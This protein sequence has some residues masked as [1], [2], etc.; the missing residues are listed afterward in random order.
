MSAAILL[1]ALAGF[2]AGSIPFSY[3]AGRLAG[4]DVRREGSGNVGATN[5]FRV[6]GRKAGVAA[7]AGD[8][9][10]SLLPV[11]AA[12]LAGAGPAG[13]AA[14]AAGVILGH[15]YSPFLGFRGGKGVLSTVAV[16]LVLFWPAAAAFAALWVPVF[17]LSGFVS[18]SSILGSLALPAA[19]LLLHA[20]APLPLF[21]GFAAAFVIFKHRANVRRL[22]AGTENRMRR[23]RGFKRPR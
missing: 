7:V 3:L 15:C 18:L 6:A 23:G 13:Q 17:L 19:A 9:L 14:C 8:L 10:K 11:V 1:W 4:K 5:V 16:S 20:P 22:V 12:R 2:A 21:F